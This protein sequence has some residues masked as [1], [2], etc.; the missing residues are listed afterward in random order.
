MADQIQFSRRE[1]QIMDVL[2]ARNGATTME[3][4]GELPDA[5][6]DLSVRRL[7]HILEEKGHVRRRMR[8]REV[9]YIPRRAKKAV[10]VR[11]L[12]HVIDTFFG[13]ELDEALAAHFA[14][15]ETYVSREQLLRIKR[16]IEEAR[17]D[18]R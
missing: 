8:G 14:K 7:L 11:A 13:G 15:K 10:G 9:V 6:S 16:L 3:V 5:P 2:Y 4:V 1:R 12:Q 17:Q 18:G